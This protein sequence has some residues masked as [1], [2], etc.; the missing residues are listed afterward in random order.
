MFEPGEIVIA[1]FPFTSLASMKRR[2]CVVLA[3][4]DSPNDFVVAFITTAAAASGL[5]SA[6]AIGPTHPAWK[7]TGLKTSSIIRADKL[8]T[9]NDSVISGAIGILPP[10]ILGAVRNKLKALLQTP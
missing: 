5:P 2:P 1:A 4:G 10:D 7:K 3:A 9:L 8:V 6:I